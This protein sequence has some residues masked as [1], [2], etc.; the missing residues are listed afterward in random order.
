VSICVRGKSIR[1]FWKLSKLWDLRSLLSL[2]ESFCGYVVASYTNRQKTV[3]GDDNLMNGF[4]AFKNN[5]SL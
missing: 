2:A 4:K 5:E 1:F 3:F